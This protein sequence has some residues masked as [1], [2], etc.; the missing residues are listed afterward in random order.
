MTDRPSTGDQGRSMRLLWGQQ[1]A[2]T[3]GPKPGASVDEIVAAAIE[4]AD[5]EGLDAVTMRKVAERL[6]RSA[7]SLYTY[8]PSKAQLLDL[9]I[10]RVQ[11]Q[12]PTAYDLAGG[13]RPA[14]E[15]QARARWQLFDR[16][17]WFLHVG[18]ARPTLGPNELDQAEAG[19][20]L[21]DGLGL[22]G[23]EMARANATLWTYVAGA[24][25]TV[26]E[27]R[28]EQ[29]VTGLSDDDWW[30]ER[31]SLLDE[32]APDFADRYPVSTR[33]QAEEQVYDQLDRAP[34]D[35]TPYLERDALD[36]FEFGLARLLDGLEALIASKRRRK[37]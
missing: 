24:A 10:D 23:L 26:A 28:R 12:L 36:T 1:T 21:F 14:V 35:D 30:V 15:A 13:W 33:L 2:P 19:L 25:R 31:S 37:R 11:G 18:W 9:M 4:L 8:V 32:L 29:Q 17:P 22:T 34:G 7:M 20:V 27:V 16:H 3:R 5:A 6:G